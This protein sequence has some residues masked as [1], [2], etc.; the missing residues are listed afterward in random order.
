LIVSSSFTLKKV[1]VSLDTEETKATGTHEGHKK[2]A[3][4]LQEGI[5]MNRINPKWTTQGKCTIALRTI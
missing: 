2:K 4:Q 5:I 3:Y 1:I